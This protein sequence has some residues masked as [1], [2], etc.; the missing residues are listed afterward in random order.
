MIEPF[1]PAL[2]VDLE[3]ALATFAAEGYA[4]LGRIA[5]DEDLSRL[6]ARADDLMEGRVQKDGLFFQLD[7]ENGDYHEL[8]YGRGWQG[9]SQRYRKIEKLELDDVF[10]AWL[11]NPVFERIAHAV[12]G[13]DVFVLR[14][15]LMTKA[16]RI[17]AVASGG[18]GERLQPG[19]TPL[20]WHQDSG[21]FWGISND[22]KLQIWTALD[23]A[24][25]ESGCVE[26][27]PRS[28]LA[29]L[30]TLQGGVV[31]RAIVDER[32]AD[33]AALPLPVRAGEVLLI[34]NLTWHRSGTNTTTATRRAFSVC[35]VD[36]TVQCTRTRKAPRQFPRVF[37][38]GSGR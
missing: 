16:P 23:D 27:F 24:P 35:L 13:G 29:G 36:P 5:S 17:E 20:P 32:G 9:P 33:T 31:P 37:A 30:A 1:S 26:V 19:G 3:G 11:E 2:P 14:A 18:G 34:H 12:L 7:A 22:P 10:R 4:R 8:P 25:I 28:H 21:R 15:M 38:H 6:R